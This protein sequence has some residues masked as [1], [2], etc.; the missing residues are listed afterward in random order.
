VHNE[1]AMKPAAATCSIWNGISSDVITAVANCTRP[2]FDC[3]DDDDSSI[4]RLVIDIK[5]EDAEVANSE[6]LS[7]ASSVE[8][9]V[10]DD[11]DNCTLPPDESV[12]CENVKQDISRTVVT[13]S[14]DEKLEPCSRNVKEKKP[15]IKTEVE[16]S[17]VETAKPADTLTDMMFMRWPA[18]TARVGA[19]LQNLGNTCFVNATVQCL[20]YTVPLANYLLTVNHSASCKSSLV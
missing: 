20:T 9:D 11:L 5:D 12:A 1:A 2:L 14:C 3:D 4:D 19:G 16:W 6:L 18:V 8:N 15:L 7:T 17:A 10:C 13:G